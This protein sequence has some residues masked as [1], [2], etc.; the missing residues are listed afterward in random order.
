L[1]ETSSGYWFS[2]ALH[3]G[4]R[5]EVFTI[6][7]KESKKS[8]AIAR[9]ADADPRA[10]ATLLDALSAMGLLSKQ[11]DTYANTEAS[12]QFLV[13]ESLEYMGFIIMHHHHLVDAW[14]HLPQSVLMGGPVR[15]RA[16]QETE[17]EAFLMGM[18]NMAMALAPQ[19]AAQIDLSGRKRLLDLGGGP[20]T[21]SIFFCKQNPQLEA[22]VFDLPSTKPF[23]RKTIERFGLGDRIR[24]EAGDYTDHKIPEGHDVAWLSQVLHSE[25]PKVCQEVIGETVAALEKGGLI[26]IHDF[27]LDDSRDS[28][29]FPALFSLNM[30][31]NTDRGQSYSE[32]E[33]RSMLEKAGVKDIRRLDFQSPSDSAIIMGNV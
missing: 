31:V 17:R 22:T 25:G 27:I 12:A 3:A 19:I 11:G 2:C 33:I 32:G 23:A 26:I 18:F 8:E 5:L 1:L 30:L 28:P 14:A 20:G 24:F 13:K 16:W 21:Y 29:L 7:G 15:D 9:E 4:V 6:L 10:M